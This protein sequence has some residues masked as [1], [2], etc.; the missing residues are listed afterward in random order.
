MTAC[1]T[2]LRV[3]KRLIYD[4]EPVLIVE[5][6]GDQVLLQRGT[7]SGSR[8]VSLGQLVA[9]ARVVGADPSPA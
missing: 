5:L 6:H 1:V 9:T 7:G 8:L 4:G 3:G 2:Q